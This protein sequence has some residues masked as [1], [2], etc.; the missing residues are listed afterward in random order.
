MPMLHVY[1]IFVWIMITVQGFPLILNG[2]RTDK[3]LFCLYEDIYFICDI[4]LLVLK[5]HFSFVIYIYII[6]N[7]VI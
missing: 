1:R 5:F 3:A 2:K 4:Y 6:E 7:L